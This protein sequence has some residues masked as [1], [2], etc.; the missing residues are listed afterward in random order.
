MPVLDFIFRIVRHVVRR[1]QRY[2]RLSVIREVPKAGT[3]GRRYR[4][5]L[6]RCDCGKHVTPRI[7]SL[8]SGD[9]Q[10]CGCSRG[11]SRYGWKHCPVCGAPAMIRR[12]RKSCSRACGY[13][14]ARAARQAANPS[15]AVWHKRVTKA[16]GPARGYACVDCGGRAEDWST[17]N[18]SSD[19]VRVRF[20]P[21]C[22]KC[23]RRYDGAV[24][25]G[26]PRATLT[27][28]RVR[29]LRARRA[30][31]LTYWQLA[32]EFG[33]SDVSAWAAV[34]GKTWRHVA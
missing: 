28:E 33:I 32:A 29:Q 16:L 8:T 20:Q 22:R 2:G 27:D 24:G 31:G 12:D 26:N 5:A 23:H 1:G 25:R 17:V 15:Y 14:L 13:Q 4:A 21:R 3:D 34:N 10:S 18:P 7:S 11:P 30:Q 19:D 6:C 9:A